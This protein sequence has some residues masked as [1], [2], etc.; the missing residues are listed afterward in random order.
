MKKEGFKNYIKPVYLLLLILTLL[1]SCKEPDQSQKQIGRLLV[2]S[3]AKNDSAFK[4]FD[5]CL[6]HYSFINTPESI[7]TPIQQKALEVPF[8][9][10]ESAHSF[11]N[12]K[13]TSNAERA[14]IRV[15]FSDSTELFGE[16]VTKDAL[17]PQKVP[18]LSSVEHSE[19]KATIFLRRSFPWTATLLQ[20]VLLHQIGTTLG[21]KPCQDLSNIF[22]LDENYV[23]VIALSNCEIEE[24]NRIYSDKCDEWEQLKD[25]PLGLQS[26]NRT[27]FSVGGKGFIY[28]D[29]WASANKLL[30]ELSPVTQEWRSRPA[31]QIDSTISGLL[32]FTIGDTAIV[33]VKINS[34]ESSVN[35]PTLLSYI[36]STDTNSGNWGTIAPLPK[37]VGP[38]SLPL[39][40]FSSNGTGYIM[41]DKMWKYVP[42][43][44]EWIKILSEDAIIPNSG[45]LQN[46]HFVINNSIYFPRIRY[47]GIRLSLS[48]FR[49]NPL[50]EINTNLSPFE[51]FICFSL[52]GSGYCLTIPRVESRS[53]LFRYNEEEGWTTTGELNGFPGKGN[54]A[55]HFTIANRAYFVTSQNEVWMYRP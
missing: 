54:I 15:V 12:F 36:S 51:P 45:F 28:M 13:Y 26:F 11:L 32:S 22:S 52:R 6:V 31:F 40:G 53:Y 16:I 19:N 4:A 34:S 2:M 50:T 38:N 30:Y 25:F 17:V 23:P 42:Q 29:S 55:A 33:G 21:L 35:G 48:S 49:W 46:P 43:S 10:W 3:T 9:H 24:L 37:P 44:N 7:Q 39:F 14:D 20:K 1:A 8:D 18:V 47:P 5:F 27:T 41:G